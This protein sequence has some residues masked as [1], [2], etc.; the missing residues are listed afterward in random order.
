MYNKIERGKYQE[1]IIRKHILAQDFC[2]L[3]LKKLE[4]STSLLENKLS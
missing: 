4:L 2:L 3:A 1:T